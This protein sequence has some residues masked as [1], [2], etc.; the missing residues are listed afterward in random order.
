MPTK[1]NLPSYRS[2][3]QS[4]LGS[5]ANVLVIHRATLNM[6]QLGSFSV[7]PIG[8]NAWNELPEPDN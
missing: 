5:L 2:A 7:P 1:P 3:F 6:E 8:V 4:V